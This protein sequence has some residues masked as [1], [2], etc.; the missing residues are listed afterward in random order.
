MLNIRH[1][2]S[3]LEPVTNMNRNFASV[4]H[5]KIE[6]ETIIIKQKALYYFQF[7]CFSAHCW[8]RRWRLSRVMGQHVGGNEEGW[9]VILAKAKSKLELKKAEQV[10][11]QAEWCDTSPKK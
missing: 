7:H 1:I 8:T 3:M 11:K 9:T 5:A 2:Y 6:R 4:T 10:T